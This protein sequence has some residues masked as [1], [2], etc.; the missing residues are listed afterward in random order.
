MVRNYVL[1]AALAGAGLL[2]AAPT[3]PAQAGVAVG[4]GVSVG[5][6][7][8]GYTPVYY[9][10]YYGGRR[11]YRPYAYRPYRRAYRR[12]AIGVYVAP[13][14]RYYRRCWIN[15]YGRRVCG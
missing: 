8:A 7:H 4:V 5:P 1:A 12:P 6:V 14:P 11:Y 15:R 2:A 13:A 9:R 10:R 3:T